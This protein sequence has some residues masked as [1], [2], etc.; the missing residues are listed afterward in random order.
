MNFK[1]LVDGDLVTNYLTIM[2][3]LQRL[4]AFEEVVG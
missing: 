2:I 1:G 4:K 3:Y